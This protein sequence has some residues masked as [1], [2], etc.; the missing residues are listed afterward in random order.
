MSDDFPDETMENVKDSGLLDPPPKKKIWSGWKDVSQDFGDS[1][2]FDLVE[3][4][5]VVG[6]LVNYQRDAGQYHQ[7]VYTL[8]TL[9]GR[10]W[11][12]WGKSA[13]NRLLVNDDGELKYPV[14]TWLRIEH[15]GMKTNPKNNREFKAFDVQASETPPPDES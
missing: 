2:T 4:P 12:V 6:K 9:G 14:G 13:L 15:T 8:V 3:S 10:K 11:S 7:R 5:V 1:F